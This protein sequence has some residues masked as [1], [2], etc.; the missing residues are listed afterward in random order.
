MGFEQKEVVLS[1]KNV[2]AQLTGAPL[3][4]SICNAVKTAI[5]EGKYMQVE[6]AKIQ[7]TLPFERFESMPGCNWLAWQSAISRAAQAKFKMEDAESVGTTILYNDRLRNCTLAINFCH[8][9][10]TDEK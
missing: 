7:L 4:D 6:Y 10:S 2:L 9:E 3:I 8:R 1:A 5:Q